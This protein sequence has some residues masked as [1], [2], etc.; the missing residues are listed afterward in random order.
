MTEVSLI[1]RS[2]ASM[3]IS[4]A[5][6]V[7]PRKISR[8]VV[9]ERVPVSPE[10]KPARACPRSV[11]RLLISSETSS[12]LPHQGEPAGTLLPVA[13]NACSIVLAQQLARRRIFIYTV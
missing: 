12:R 8:R 7:A 5:R 2:S 11:Y 9:S 13:S 10:Q 3:L 4:R 1:A 6:K